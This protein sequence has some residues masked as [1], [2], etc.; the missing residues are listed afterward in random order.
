MWP[1]NERGQCRRRT[2]E[3][4]KEVN[5]GSKELGVVDKLENNTLVHRVRKIGIN[6]CF[7]DLPSQLITGRVLKGVMICFYPTETKQR[8]TCENKP[9]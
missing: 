3:H 4:L 7:G 8:S 5:D 1:H 2:K 9:D 6:K